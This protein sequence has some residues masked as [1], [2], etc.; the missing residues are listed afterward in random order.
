MCLFASVSSF[1][2]GASG[3]DWDVAGNWSNNTVPGS[4]NENVVNNTAATI[5]LDTGG[6]TIN[7]FDSTSASANL[8]LFGGGLH[9]SVPGT[10]S[11]SMNGS[12]LLGGNTTLSGFVVNAA[13]ITNN[14]IASL[15]DVTINSGYFRALG[16]TNTM[17]SGT[18]TLNQGGPYVG[19]GV[20]GGGGL[21][22]LLT[23]ASDTILKG[24]SQVGLSVLSGGGSTY[25]QGN[26][27]TLTNDT[28][29][30]GAGVI[31]NG[32]L[33][34]VNNGSI[35]A[36]DNL[37]GYP[38]ASSTLT[39]NGGLINNNGTLAAD[40]A[41]NSNPNS[42]S[43]LNLSGVTVNNAGGQ[44][45]ANAAGDNVQLTSGTAVQGG[46][47]YNL[48]GGFLGTTTGNTATLDGSTHGALTINGQY[49]C[50]LASTTYIQ[51]NIGFSGAINV[52]GGAGTNGILALNGAA[53]L[54]GLGGV[55]LNYEGGSGGAYLQGNNQTLTSSVTIQ[56]NGVIGN[57]SLAL[58]NNGTINADISGAVLTLNGSGGITNAGLMEA[59]GGGILNLSNTPINNAGGSITVKDAASAVEIT[60]TAVIWGGTLTNTAGGFLGTPQGEVA[61]LNG[62]THGA[63]TINGTYTN[64]LGS[65]TYIQGNI[66]NNGNI[67]VNGNPGSG[68]PLGLFL[69][70]NTTLQGSGT[71]TLSSLGGAGAAI[72]GTGI[73]Y[74][75]ANSIIQG[76]GYVVSEGLALVNSGTINA[77]VTG[78]G[79]N[80]DPAGGITNTGIIE[81]SGGSGLAI[82]FVPVNNNGG[83]ITANGAGDQVVFSSGVTIQGGTLNNT[84]GGFLGTAGS[85]S[86]DGTTH[87][88]LTINGTYT[89]PQNSIT[90]IQGNIQNYGNI[91]VNGGVSANGI[92]ALTGATTLNGDG[93]VTLNSVVFGA[94][95]QGDGQTLTNNSTIQG[96]G[97]IGNG[98]LA[99]VNNGTID[100]NV[101]GSGIN[102]NG[103]GG[104]TNTGLIEA[105]NNGNL[106]MQ[107]TIQ[108]SGNIQINGGGGSV[109]DL[110]LLGNTT[111]SGGGAVTLNSLPI[112]YAGI[113]GFSNPETLENVDN[114]IQGTG[115][116]GQNQL[117]LQN[118]AAGTVLANV[119]GGTLEIL[120]GSVTNNGTFQANAGSTLIVENTTFT[121]FSGN[122]LTGG[123]YIVNGE[124]GSPGTL[125]IST[126]G[127]TGGEIVNNVASIVLNGPNSNFVDAAGLD[128]LSK[129]A[130]NTA[131]GSF[132]ISGGRNF[133]TAG[134]FNNAGSVTIGTGSTMQIGPT[135]TNNYIQSGGVT[136]V[137]GLL[138]PTAVELNGGVLAGTG[139]ITA[140]NVLA[141][142]GSIAPGTAAGT[143]ELTINGNLNDSGSTL[144]IRLGGVGAGEFDVLDVNG[145]VNLGAGSSLDVYLYDGFTPTNG[146][147]FTFLDFTG[148]LTSQNPDFFGSVFG[149]TTAGGTF[150]ISEDVD[151]GL[152][153]TFTANTPEPGA[154][155]MLLGG[156]AAWVMMRRRRK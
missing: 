73:L 48:N 59:T 154:I 111:L 5:L 44:I 25:L 45:Y 117:S 142:G 141:A 146:E 131:T 121:N 21:N 65:T 136:T 62:A 76:S 140:A 115:L 52:N 39:M 16:G 74:N 29:I 89:N 108:N 92:L 14:N 114:T 155:V 105:T 41:S 84:N 119:S 137:N 124:A 104:V 71:V 79:L 22:A 56:G 2:Q 129:L 113:T 33:A 47:L 10:S 93:S 90:Y 17:L 13:S 9:A 110:F 130:N 152:T 139:S 66:Q 42:G 53:T 95:I 82:Y 11:L 88:A 100:A 50:S 83:S 128:A 126:L 75:G 148:S 38:T 91:Q 70:G 99:L 37:M 87:G 127:S 64:D 123:T 150:E 68:S 35:I 49:T 57:G 102:M 151:P 120:G 28:T 40:A 134:D 4:A 31:G 144:I 7:S 96:N 18:I 34:V 85:A 6:Y 112:G 23:L 145:N 153:L 97:N 118:D 8:E 72:Q 19:M 32:S 80:L 125:Q 143:G 61:Y 116:I 122:T 54:T 147:T 78:S 103:T 101:S 46:Q 12:L 27:F 86:L 81:A 106:S 30:G 133:N 67:Q 63:L 51:G 98:S 24:A 109:S 26:G 43:T 20:A 138:D 149:L 107:G 36:N 55:Q 156:A 132:T 69:T 135:G 3:G 60:G 1:W 58:V 77:N 15:Q 94:Y